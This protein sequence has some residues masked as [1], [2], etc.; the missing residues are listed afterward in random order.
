ML[1]RVADLDHDRRRRRFFIG[2]DDAIDDQLVFAVHRPQRQ[3]ASQERARRLERAV[4]D[5]GE[6][7]GVGEQFLERPPARLV[8]ARA[9]QRFGRDVEI[10]NRARTIDDQHAGA[11]TVEDASWVGHGAR[12]GE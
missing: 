12:G 9:E 11:E 4:D 2:R 7:V 1:S 3:L 5:R 8:A 6:R 10:E